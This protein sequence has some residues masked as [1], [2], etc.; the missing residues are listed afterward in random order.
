M[1]FR[2]IRQRVIPKIAN[3]FGS[4]FTQYQGDEWQDYWRKSKFVLIPRGFG[5][6][7]FML[8]EAVQKGYVAVYIYS[9][10]S[11]APFMDDDGWPFGVAVNETVAM[12]TLPEVLRKAEERYDEYRKTMYQYRNLWTYAG[13]LDEIE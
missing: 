6:S 2:P 11:W 12:T 10:V 7:A 3:L 9:D 4:N 1:G 8:A 5:R 13:L